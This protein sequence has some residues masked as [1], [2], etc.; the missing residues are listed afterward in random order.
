MAFSHS[1]YVDASRSNFYD[2]GGN[3][4]A[5]NNVQFDNRTIHIN[6]TLSGSQA[7]G[8]VLQEL[9]AGDRL[10]LSISGLDTLSPK[11]AVVPVCYSS[12]AASGVDAA[13]NLVVQLVRLLINRGASPETYRDL[14]RDLE[15]L[16]Q[17]LVLTRLAIQVYQYTPLGQSL[18]R[19]VS[20][21]AEKCRVMLQEV[22]DGTQSCRLGLDPTSISALWRQVWWRGWDGTELASLRMKLSAC[23]ESLGRFLIALNSYVSPFCCAIAR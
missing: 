8:N 13:A 17:T 21:E 4:N 22:L 23:R 18:A 6:V 2:I 5:N 14:K 19:T 9:N 15:S 7:F 20:P 12:T 1:R 10:P 3:Y 11:G 16:H